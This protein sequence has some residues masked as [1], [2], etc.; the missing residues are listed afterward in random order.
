MEI[1]N[2]QSDIWLHILSFPCFYV[3]FHDFKNLKIAKTTSA[4]AYG[5]V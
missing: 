1:E 2:V 4:T 3:I 5:Y